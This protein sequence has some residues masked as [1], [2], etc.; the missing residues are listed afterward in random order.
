MAAAGIHEDLR[1]M[2]FH[3]AST[4]V[5]KTVVAQQIGLQVLG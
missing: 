1:P 4:R 3:L 2:R 5:G